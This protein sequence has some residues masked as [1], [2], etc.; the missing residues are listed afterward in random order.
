MTDKLKKVTKYLFTAATI[1]T[2]LLYLLAC[3]NPYAPPSQYWLIGLLGLVFPILFFLMIGLFFT[4]L[5]V[6]SRWSWVCLAIILL[7]W[8]QIKVAFGFRLPKEF[9]VAK[10]PN[11]LRV[12][13]WNVSSWDE[14]NKDQKKGLTYRRIMLD[15][16]EA[17][18][19][20]VLCFQEFFESH[21]PTYFDPTTP[22][23][24]SMGFKYHYFC[25]SLMWTIEF[26]MGVTILSKYPIVD[27]AQ[28]SYGR[29]QLAE[30]LI[31]ADI[32]VNDQ[33]IRVMTTH[34]QSVK[35][36]KEDYMN[37]SKIKNTNQEGFI[38]SKTTIGKVKRAYTFRVP[39]ADT[40]RKYINQSP[41]PVIVCGDFNDV[42]NSFT[43]FKIKGNLQDAFV[44]QGSG[45]GRTFQYISPT[46]RIDYILADK[47]FKVNQFNK[48]T[49][50]Y[51]DHYPIVADFNLKPNQ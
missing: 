49:V 21:N 42:P 16:V 29:N 41:Y 14:A 39:Q 9:N 43:Y 25:P 28:H 2:I 51:S 7:G 47:K 15:L 20:D 48:I 31:Y 10:P 8:Q 34:L 27:T 17:Q 37:L 13:Q 18:N 46:L 40:V 22:V 30:N 44:Q 26:Q 35:F 19:A 1:F 32:K 6:K 33:I 5:F 11:T 38:E 36:S 24:D 4:W 45:L 3:L 23:L 12:M 50:P